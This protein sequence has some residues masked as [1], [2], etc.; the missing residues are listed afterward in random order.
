MRDTLMPDRVYECVVMVLD[1]NLDPVEGRVVVD[2][3]NKVCNILLEVEDLQKIK[4]SDKYR[5]TRAS[6][7]G[8]N[9]ENIHAEYK[10]I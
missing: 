9:S 7:A 3:Y 10:K 6:S 4:D 5:L 2:E 1:Y 8:L